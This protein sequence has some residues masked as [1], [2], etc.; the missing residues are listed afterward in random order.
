M[1]IFTT[2]TIITKGALSIIALYY[3][4]YKRKYRKGIYYGIGS[5]ISG[6]PLS[7]Y[8]KLTQNSE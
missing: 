7:Y 3:I 5:F 4:F 2:S 6:L 8:L 1:S